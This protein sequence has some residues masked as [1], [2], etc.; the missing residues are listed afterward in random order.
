MKLKMEEE[1]LKGK[2]T[3]FYGD[4]A[5]RVNDFP[6]NLFDIAE[7]D[8]RR[9]KRSQAPKIILAGMLYPIIALLNNAEPGAIIGPSVSLV[10]LGTLL[11]LG[12]KKEIKVGGRNHLLILGD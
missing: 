7:I 6:I 10:V 8:I 2:I 5:L 11:Y 12:R 1:F 9:K 3:G 4:T